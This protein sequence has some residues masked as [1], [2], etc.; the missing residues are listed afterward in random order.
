MNSKKL[1]HWSKFNALYAVCSFKYWRKSGVKCDCFS[2]SN[3]SMASIVGISAEEVSMHTKIRGTNH[4][5]IRVLVKLKCILIYIFKRCRLFKFFTKCLYSCFHRMQCVHSKVS[6]TR[7]K[8]LHTVVFGHQQ[9]TL[10]ERKTP[11]FVHLDTK[12][13]PIAQSY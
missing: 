5:S 3:S 1:D 11:F 9:A 6:E 4:F 13:T 8:K 12:Q 10:R 2:I 7:T